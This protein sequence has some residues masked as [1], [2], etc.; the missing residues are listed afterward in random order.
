MD[1]LSIWQQNVNK[2]SLCQHDI[3]SN[4]GLVTKGID[5]I[6]LQ[7]PALSG[8]GLTIASRDWVTIYPSNHANNPRKTRSITL[9]RADANSESW[10]QLEFPSSDVT[11]TQ[12]TGTWGKITIFNIY[13]N[14]ESEVTVD[15]LT[16]YH[17]KNR[18]SLERS[19]GGEAHIMWLGDFNRHHP[20]WDNPEDTRLFTNE[21]SE[22]AEK[23][24][25]AVTDAGLDLAL[26]S[27]LPMH[28][29]SV[30]K[31][32]T[33]LDQ[34]FLSTHSVEM[35]ISCDTLPEERGVN[36]DHLLVLTE[37]RLEVTITAAEPILNFRDV[38]WEE[39]R[40]ELGKQLGKTPNPTR[41]SNQAQLDARCEELT[42]ALQETIRAEVPT[43]EITPKSKR[44]WTKELT[45]L[46][47]HANKLGR[48]TY[49]LRNTPDHCTHKDHKVAKS[50]Y[51]NMLKT[52][53]QRHWRE[54]LE[55]AEDPDI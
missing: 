40:A 43:V 47:T 5:L 51:Q 38:N 18:A 50:K 26:P 34:V 30:T 44:W 9:I 49:T 15:L 23:L 16:E 13:N 48:V 27:R 6:A 7:E 28:E 22:A 20:L 46:C 52:T 14:G 32:W 35:L 29:H 41:I 19:P 17:H 53:K 36:T 3:I 8:S 55:K 54:W 45:Q 21:A 42:K 2:S 39:F 37:L 11:V 1:R 31:R 25:D 24:I 4:K 33:R 10:N 12:I